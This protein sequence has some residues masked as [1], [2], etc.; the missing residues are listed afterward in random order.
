[1]LTVEAKANHTPGAFG[2]FCEGERVVAFDLLERNVV[3]GLDFIRI[4]RD[5]HARAYPHHDRRDEIAG[6][7]RIVVEQ[8]QHV[9]F[10]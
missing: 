6:A 1:V 2:D 4:R 8:A 9:A 5:R 10:A 3:H 7:G